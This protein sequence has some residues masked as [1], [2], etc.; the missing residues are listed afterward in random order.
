M[1]LKIGD[2][3]VLFVVVVEWWRRVGGELDDLGLY[4]RPGS[5]WC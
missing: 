5:Y 2:D 4:G 3:V 1:Y